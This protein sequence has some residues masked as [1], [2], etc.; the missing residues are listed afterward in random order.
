M[1]THDITKYAETALLS[2]KLDTDKISSTE[3]QHMHGQSYAKCLGGEAQDSS[4]RSK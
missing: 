4:K 1:E 3:I 2:L